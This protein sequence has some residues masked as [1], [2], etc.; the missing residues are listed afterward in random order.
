MSSQ[1]GFS[2]TVVGGIQDVSALL[3]LLGTEQCEKHVGSALDRGFLYSAV[4]PISIFGSLGIVRASFNILVANFNIQRYRFLGAKKLD[5]GGFNPTG[6]V[7]PM[8]ALDPKHSKRFLA[9]SRL[10]A[11]LADEHIE[12]VEDLTV[13]WGKGISWWNSMLVLF[14]LVIAATGLIPYISL[15][16]HSDHPNGEPLFPSG[17]GFPIC[18]V[19]GSA[20]CV[21]VAQFVIQLR[22][23][24]L[25]KTRLLFTTVDRLAK[26]ADIDVEL[27]INGKFERRAGKELKQMWSSD[28]ASEKCIWALERWFS[29]RAA[30]DTESAENYDVL[31]QIYASQYKRQLESIHKFI[32]PWMN[33]LL[34]MFLVAGISL[35]IGGYIG[36]FYLIQHASNGPIGP[37]LWLILEATLSVIRMLVWALNPSWDDSKGVVFEL[38]LASHPPLITC[39]KFQDDISAD[40]V[41]AITRSNSFLEEVVAYTGP[42]PLF[43]ADDVAL[44]YIFTARGSNTPTNPDPLP[45]G[46]LYIIISD[47]KEQTSRILFRNGKHNSFSI[48][49]S[50]LEPVPG[51]TAINAKVDFSKDGI[52]DSKSHFLTADSK[53]MDQLTAHYD[54]IISQLQMQKFNSNR[55]ASFG[56]TWSMQRPQEEFEK[57]NPEDVGHAAPYLVADEK[58]YDSLT[59]EDSVYLRQGQVERRWTSL[60]KSLEEWTGIYIALYMKE[61]LEDVPVDLVFK[62]NESVTLVQKHEANEVEYLLIEC[63]KYMEQFLWT[64]SKYWEGLLLE[65]H[66]EM[67]QKVLEGTFTPVVNKDDASADDGPKQHG[68]EIRKAKLKVRLADERIRLF[69]KE[70][71]AR[72][73][74]RRNRLSAQASA[75]EQ[76]VQGRKYI[77]QVGGDILQ[78]W[79]GLPE[80]IVGAPN[81]SDIDKADDDRSSSSHSGSVN[82]SAGAAADVSVLTCSTY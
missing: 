40:G 77:D 5:D 42:L 53:F 28:L 41:S 44:Y 18:R 38:Q 11:M 8:I 66:E 3:P 12:N 46:M 75:T 7:A 78:I 67:V 29:T 68:E 56:L 21:T 36:C 19:L 32:P 57:T 76:R 22:I 1:N 81:E 50:S 37:L 9:E 74:N 13:S 59:N 30:D 26:E 58:L 25:L 73:D 49:I 45:Q 31:H 48:Y 24:V 39:S 80:E 63:R 16:R 79:K 14:T 6:V 55:K 33:P 17:W 43:N 60:F 65:N 2:Q 72:A 51:S 52:T 62:E 64:T 10:E 15:I 23:L 4:T 71:R 82:K 27:Q 70:A 54:E 47:Y 20:L 61:L 69:D 35:T 34:S